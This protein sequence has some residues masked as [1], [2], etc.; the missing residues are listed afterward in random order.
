[1]IRIQAG[2][3]KRTTNNNKQMNVSADLQQRYQWH[4]ISSMKGCGIHNSKGAVLAMTKTAVFVLV[5]LVGPSVRERQTVS[6]SGSGST[7]RFQSSGPRDE[8]QDVAVRTNNRMQ[9]YHYLPGN[10][11][12]VAIFP[13]S[14]ENQYTSHQNVVDPLPLV[15]LG[16]YQPTGHGDRP[17]YPGQYIRL[18]TQ[19]VH[20][21][22]AHL[23]MKNPAACRVRAPLVIARGQPPARP[24]HAATR[25][26]WP[27]L[28]RTDGRG[29]RRT[30]M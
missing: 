12:L 27:P 24:V 4:H 13:P 14:I 23:Q 25:W 19:A 22:F 18:G 21:M 16:Q 5:V 29:I 8:D 11:L 15:P 20:A 6:G 3:A 9:P 7:L 2:H 26:L 30:V 1:M 28:R 10:T 17:P